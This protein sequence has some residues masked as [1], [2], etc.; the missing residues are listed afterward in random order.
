MIIIS[1]AGKN[2]LVR[3]VMEHVHGSVNAGVIKNT[4]Y[5]NDK[6]APSGGQG[7]TL[8]GEVGTQQ[9]L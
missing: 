1:Y 7:H 9:S 2:S 4:L 5:M 8:E 6:G 3:F